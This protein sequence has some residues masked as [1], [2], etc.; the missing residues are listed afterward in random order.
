MPAA[1]D[2]K[3][4]RLPLVIQPGN[5]DATTNKDAKLV[6]CFVE[7][8]EADG[9][10][11][12]YKRPGLVTQSTVS[13]STPGYGV[14]NWNGDIYSI[15]GTGLY[16]NGTLVGTVDSTGGV[17]RFTSI[18]GA[19]PAMVF[20]NGVQL[21]SYNASNGLHFA[22]GLSQVSASGMFTA[23]SKVVTNITPNTTG[24]NPGD[25]VTG[26]GVA[27]G[28]TI[29]TVDSASQITMSAN[30]TITSP[31]GGSNIT[32]SGLGYMVTDHFRIYNINLYGTAG[33]S[34][35]G[36][37]S[38]VVVFNTIFGNQVLGPTTITSIDN[39]TQ[40]HVAM[41][42]SPGF[43]GELQSTLRIDFVVV[44]VAAVPTPFTTTKQGLATPQVKGIAC[45]D[46]TVYQMNATAQIV[47]SNLNDPLTWNPLNVLTAQIEPDGGVA[48]AKQL[49]YVIAL[50]G[51][52]CEVFQD[53]ANATG[54]PLGVVAGAN[55][56][57]GCISADS[58]RNIEG[59]LYWVGTTKSGSTEIYAMT[60]LTPVK[61]STKAIDRIISDADYTTVYSFGVRDA[62]H[63]Y[64]VLTI[65]NNNI[66]LVY[67]ITE[68]LWYQWTDVNGNYLPIVDATFSGTHTIVQHESN[69]KLY[70]FQAETFTD[71][72]TTFSV[73]VV[74]PIFDGG[75]KAVK[76]MNRLD[77]IGDQTPGSIVYARVSDDD[78]QH[79]SNFRAIDMNRKNPNITGCGSFYK[80]AYHL[81]HKAPTPLR[82]KAIEM[83]LELGEK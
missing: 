34:N 75:T 58:V 15:F 60:N 72:G 18:L 65:K 63:L 83:Q 73:D 43:V 32:Y 62:G 61:I 42:L 11:S 46:A 50:K 5:R 31:P 37:I 53:N 68:G 8:N 71:D 52:T 47:G 80:R 81:R 57:M 67:D 49:S 6:N 78:Y 69:G 40:I 25:L 29:A 7:K 16:K 13:A 20:S 1:L 3:P 74:T 2:E 45:L 82:I 33:Y 59:S 77:I 56:Q 23:G 10:Y 44:S 48:L 30:A 55:P 14:Y 19:L 64:Y 79:W 4:V 12:L 66:T 41:D 39:A 54:S 17:Y 27:G 51:W 28:T 36:A 22:P 70:Y 21:Y 76:T 26:N 35:G 38:N 9:S 24:M